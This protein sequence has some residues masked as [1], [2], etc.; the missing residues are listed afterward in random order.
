MQTK[1]LKT[2]CAEVINA[3]IDLGYSKTIVNAHKQ[4]YSRLQE[5]AVGRNV[6]VF[7]QELAETFLKEC[8]SYSYG[9]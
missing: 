8:F 7:S 2:S 1:P 6:A 3:L 4:A 5:F 9:M